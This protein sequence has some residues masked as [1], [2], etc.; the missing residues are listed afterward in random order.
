MVTDDDG[1]DDRR[2]DGHDDG[3]LD[4][5]IDTLTQ[6]GL[7]GNGSNYHRG[8]GCCAKKVDDGGAEP[9]KNQEAA[10]SE[11]PLGLRGRRGMGRRMWE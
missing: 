7:V 4:V 5:E 6:N 2:Y 1:C 10:I 11:K 8:K 3:R 9:N